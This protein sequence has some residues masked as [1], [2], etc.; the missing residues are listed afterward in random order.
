MRTNHIN[1]GG[2][3]IGLIIVLIGALL[4]LDQWN[5]FHFGS[6]IS[7]FWPL[8]VL[9]IGM[10]KYREGDRKS[11]FILLG[12]GAVF[13]LA[14]LGILEWRSI[15]RLW[16][17]F[18]ILVGLS[19]A[20]G[21][22]NMFYH[23]CREIGE[24]EFDINVV[25]GGSERRIT[26]Q[27]LTGGEVAAFFGGA[28]VDLREASPADDCRIRISAIFGGVELRIPTDWQIVLTGTPILG[29]IEDK[30]RQEADGPVVRISCN[31]VLGGIEI[32]N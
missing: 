4:L 18:I 29:G 32:R 20:Y 2:R 31:V 14:T 5:I 1:R 25:F 22:R 16:P 6:I 17:V 9:L 3:G 8:I 28:E 21:G 23:S 27:N 30:T 10:V 26:N 12:M 7:T 13:L 11:A 24:D 15:G 19:I